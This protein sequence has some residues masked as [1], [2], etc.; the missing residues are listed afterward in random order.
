MLLLPQGIR[1]LMRDAQYKSEP[2]AVQ[3]KMSPVLLFE[4]RPSTWFNWN[5]HRGAFDCEILVELVRIGYPHEPFD[6][7]PFSASKRIDG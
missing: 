5:Q 3:T 6:T 1:Y 2:M 7:T 4:T